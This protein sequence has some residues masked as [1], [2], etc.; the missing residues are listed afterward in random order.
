V[1]EMQKSSQEGAMHIDEMT[2]LLYI[3]GQLDRQRAQSVSAHTQECDACRTLLRAMERESRLLKRAM[4]EEE[5][6]LP[7]RLA[8]L[9]ER[10]R[11]SMQWLW[12]V[13]FGL[14]A[15]GVYALYTGYVEPWQQ[16]LE[17]AGFGG[18]SLL[19]LMIFQGA[20]WKGWQSMITLLEVLALLTL[21]MFAVAFFRRRLRRASALMVMLAGLCAAGALAPVASATET[22]HAETVTV[23]KD[24]TVKGDLFAFAERTR[25]DGTVEGDLYV[26]SHHVKVD[27]NVKGD[28]I[29]FA[30]TLEISGQVDGNVRS[31]ANT[32]TITGTVAKNVL[33]GNDT[34]EVERTGKIG[35]SLT[36]FAGAV[37]IE[38]SLGRDL[39]F[40]GNRIAISG[41]VNGE[42]KGKGDTLSIRSGAVI[43]GPVRFE[44]NHEPNVSPEAKLASPV[45]FHQSQHERRYTEAGFY[46]WRI[47]W[48]AAIV[49][50]GMV[51]FVLMPRFARDAVS[52][53]ENYGASIGLGLLVSFGL[54]I[55]ALIACVT[56]VGLFL[57]IA[58]FMLWLLALSCAQIV[59][60][61]VVGQ[62]LLGK[63]TEL[64]PLIGRMAVGVIII[65]LCTSIP[66]GGLIRVGVI[67][68]GMG[69]IS[70]ALYR[71][72]QPTIATGAPSGPVVTSP[73]PP[74]TTVG[75]VQPA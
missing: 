42:I 25:I 58:A 73:L 20:F 28:V 30:E 44:G 34:I 61:T 63:T 64:W 35:G 12:G 41:A 65:K 8:Q 24:E 26:F 16:Q 29:A 3:E 10:A 31:F 6:A 66:H 57:G 59:V 9:Q 68:W 52:S 75:G 14:A 60:G 18:S 2:C 38:G 17:Q 1:N 21:G 74:N 71:R 72:F 7:V 40:F 45:E 36:A 54:P 32:V 43:G 5:E 22:R 13:A 4:L 48:T 46:V 37:D 49:L 47:I 55:A 62:W 69:A 56:V 51:L 70:L 39:L 11:N 67:F 50:F 23:A 53:A 19:S 33:T 15:T 27:G